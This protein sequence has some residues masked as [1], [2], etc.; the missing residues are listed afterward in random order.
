MVDI[1]T[2]KKRMGFKSH[3]FFY[4]F[5]LNYLATFTWSDESDTVYH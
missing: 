1:I 5:K 3:P 2:N 4:R